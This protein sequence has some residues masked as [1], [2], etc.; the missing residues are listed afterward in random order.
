[1][2]RF[3]HYV[4]F[5]AIEC[6]PTCLR[7][8]A[9]YYNSLQILSTHLFITRDKVSLL[10]IRDVA[11]FIGFY[12]MGELY[13]TVCFMIIKEYIGLPGG[14]WKKNILGLKRK[15]ES[16]VKDKTIPTIALCG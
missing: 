11:E 3:H 5:N 12:I 13:F 4:Q 6:A 14:K 2:K 10:G 1:M 7:M 9:Q 16:I 15:A 8:S